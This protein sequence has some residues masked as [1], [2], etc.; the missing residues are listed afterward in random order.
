LIA[1]ADDNN[2]WSFERNEAYYHLQPAIG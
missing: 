1:Y 2:Q